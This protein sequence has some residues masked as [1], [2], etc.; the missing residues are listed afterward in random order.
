M[1]IEPQSL[2]GLLLLKPELIGDERGYFAETYRHDVL[3]EASGIP[4]NFVQDN[5]SRS[6]YGV[7]RGL[8]YQKPPYA[9]T[10]LVRVTEGRVLDVAV[11]IRHGSPTFGQSFCVELSS[12][13][14]YQL[15]VPR[16][17]AHGFAVLSE[18]ATLSYRV[19]NYYAP[20]HDAGLAFDDPVL[21]IDWRL[22]PADIILSAKDQQQPA[23]TELHSGFV[24]TDDLYQR[25]PSQ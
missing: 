16:G 9:Q 20:S 3:T 18:F 24:F 13:N 17:F 23:L 21:A 7:L 15:L 4:F 1:I 6:R 8:H 2:S 10:K 19:D 25:L 22:P 14:K 11:D 5:E 12:D